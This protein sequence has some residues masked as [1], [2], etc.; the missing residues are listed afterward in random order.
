M[1]FKCLSVQVPSPS[2]SFLYGLSVDPEPLDLGR[3][4]PVNFADCTQM[5][6]FNMFFC[7]ISYKLQLNPEA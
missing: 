2:L 3:E 1:A 4:L 6:K 7:P 5:I